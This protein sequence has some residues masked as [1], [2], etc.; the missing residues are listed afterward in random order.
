MIGIPEDKNGH[1][2]TVASVPSRLG[3]I[4]CWSFHLPEQ[5]ETSELLSRSPLFGR[6]RIAENACVS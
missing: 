3:N 5:H 6:L 1:A 2:S 4:Q